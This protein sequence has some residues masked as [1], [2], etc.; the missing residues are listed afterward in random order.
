MHIPTL[1]LRFKPLSCVK[2]CIAY[3]FFSTDLAFHSM[4]SSQE[5]L[6]CRVGA[7]RS[8]LVD[9]AAQAEPWRRWSSDGSKVINFEAP[10]F[11]GIFVRLSWVHTMEETQQQPLHP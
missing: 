1:N 10:I 9:K 7:G 3:S 11:F 5:F 2:I 6:L 4:P 8:Y